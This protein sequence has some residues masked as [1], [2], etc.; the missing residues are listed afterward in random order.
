M[1]RAPHPRDQLGMPIALRT[2]A[3]GLSAAAGPVIRG[4]LVADLGWRAVFFLTVHPALVTG[5]L[6]LRAR[7]P[8]EAP[9]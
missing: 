5:V 6:P 2:S 8:G 3:I 4:A 9:A 7:S 1:L